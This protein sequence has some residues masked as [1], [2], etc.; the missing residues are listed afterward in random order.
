[1]RADAA[2]GALVSSKVNQWTLL[3]GCLPI[4]YAISSGTIDPLPTDGRQTE[5]V[6][7][8]AAQSLLAVVLLINLRMSVIEA[9]SL[10]VLFVAQFFMPHSIVPRDVF[11]IMYVALAALFAVRQFFEMRPFMGGG[12]ASRLDR[13]ADGH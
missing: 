3:I 10:A 1:M 13:P 8:T 2:L 9:G 5:E 7:L 11:S 6:L 4:A 12:A